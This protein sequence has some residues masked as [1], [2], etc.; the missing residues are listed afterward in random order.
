MTRET[1]PDASQSTSAGA[2]ALPPLRIAMGGAVGPAAVPEPA[3]SP[4][5]VALAP[6]PVQ[7]GTGGQAGG[8]QV[9]IPSLTRYT[10]PLAD[11]P[12][13]IN[14]LPRQLL[15]DQAT[16]ATRDA[17]RNVPG[18]SLAA[19]EAGSQGDNL[20]LRGFSARNDFFLDGMR[21]F[22]SY[23]RDPF[24]L[25]SIEV[26][27]G[28]SSITFGRGS[29]G[30]VINQVSKQPGLAP[31]TAGTVTLG[32]DGT[33]RITTDVNR[34]I[35]GLPGTAVRL[36]LLLHENGVADRNVGRYRRFA[37]AP[38]VA[39]GLGTPTR[40]VLSYLHQQSFDTPDYG[41]PWLYKSP[42]QV[43]RQT[44]YGYKDDDYYRSNVDIV[45]AK[46]EHDFSSNLAVRNQF[47]YGNYYRDI[48]VTEPQILYTGVNPVVRPTT[49][50]DQITVSRNSIAAKATETFVQ[51]QADV[52]ARFSTG[53]LSHT[54]VAGIEGG[55]ETSSPARL[56]YANVPYQRT[57]LLYPNFTVPFLGRATVST[58]SNTTVSGAAGYLIDTIKLGEQW[59]LTGGIRYDWL[60]TDYNLTQA[61]A[62]R[63]TELNRTDSMPSYRV[64]LSYK[65]VPEGTVYFAYGTSFN[66][67]SDSLTLATSTAGLA[68]EENETYEVG[69]KWEVFDR[70]LTLGA[71]LF[72]S[73]KLNARVNDPNNSLFQILGGDQLVR[74]YELTAL[75]SIT[76]RWQIT[77]GFAY[78]N[79]EVVKTTLANTQGRVLP[80]V[81]RYS[82]SLFTT[83]Q[84]PWY[85][86]QV[87]G[88]FNAL[89]PRLASSTP[90]ATTGALLVAPGYVTVQAFVK[91]P[92][93]PG[94][95]LQVN[96]FNLT[97]Q[98]Y[99][100]LLHPAHV[101]PGAGRAV[102]A[103]LNFRL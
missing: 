72:Q 102:L 80:N 29:T 81:P 4:D 40:F 21:D 95:D 77:A 26:L 74:G 38:S 16:T 20:T 62:P 84:L 99:Y 45:T 79:S 11:T 85:G 60:Y 63:R 10:Q 70:K 42:A 87:G 14:V 33:R 36:N 13:T 103:S 98:K 44:F 32:T 30:G 82:G 68:P 76:D 31:I 23:V 59:A 28:P 24:N 52:T 49:P 66:P 7:G 3:A 15:D 12:Q 27:K 69:A 67:S 71:A 61:A 35:P 91:V 86:V 9:S 94:L 53:P 56:L 47:R 75:G 92:L 50:L 65:P 100:D 17:L 2:A 6:I 93:R 54:L 97:N 55:Q 89:S 8:Y 46:L 1:A 73:E 57:N 5:P 19:G 25:E 58:D 34:A 48:R 88:G 96:G 78:L 39:F 22:G 43:P 18:L 90:N 64:A 37:V 101:V 41:L 51:N 83:Y